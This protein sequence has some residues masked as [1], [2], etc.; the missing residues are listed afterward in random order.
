MRRGGPAVLGRRVVVAGRSGGS[1]PGGGRRTGPA[2]VSARVA[3]AIVISASVSLIA[4]VFVRPAT[5]T[6]LAG[7]VAVV[8]PVVM[9]SSVPLV[10]PVAVSIGAA[11]ALRHEKAVDG[12]LGSG[13]ALCAFL[14]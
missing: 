1:R 11:V 10:G 7:V 12:F 3:P 8:A 2:A 6:H 13:A 5:A 14:V 4:F 9:A